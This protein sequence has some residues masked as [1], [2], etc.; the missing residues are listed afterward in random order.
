MYGIS[1]KKASS[2]KVLQVAVVAIW[3][4]KV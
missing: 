1:L 4:V 3:N 2:G